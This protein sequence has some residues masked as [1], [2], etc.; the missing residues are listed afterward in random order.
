M[1][2]GLG[3]HQDQFTQTHVV[4]IPRPPPNSMEEMFRY[5]KPSPVL[6]AWLQSEIL[7]HPVSWCSEP[8]VGKPLQGRK[9][10]PMLIQ[11]CGGEGPWA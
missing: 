1:L 7:M 5:D 10:L 2:Q 4:D 8:W 6:G 11:A 9:M 3:E